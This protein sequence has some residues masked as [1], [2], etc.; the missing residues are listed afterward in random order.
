M[1]KLPALTGDTVI[2]T[3]EKI[4]FETVRQKGSH[5]RMQHIDGRVLTVP[6]HAGK[7]IGKGLLSK[8][9]RDAEISRDE[10]IELI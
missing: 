10:F 1:S 7:T 5:V 4:G 9:I 8:I 6:I 3:L 2:K